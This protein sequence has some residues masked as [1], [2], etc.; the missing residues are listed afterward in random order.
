MR[1]LM[2]AGG[3]TGGHVYPLLSVLE[4]LRSLPGGA[5]TDVLFLGRAGATEEGL[6]R[7]HGVPFAPIAAG[8]VVGM[9]PWRLAR[10]LGKV[11]RGTNEALREVRR[12]D[13]DVI[14]VTGGYVS[15]PVAL[16]G[17]LAR[18]P[19]AV[20]LPDMEPGL[21]VR[22]LAYL[23]QRVTVSF[24]EVQ[25]KLPR[26]KTVVTGYPVRPHLLKGDRVAA[27]RRLGVEASEPMLLVLGGSSGARNINDAVLASLPDLLSQAR[28]F[29]LTGT[30]DFE[31]VQAAAKD[32]GT[33]VR[34]K[35]SIYSYVEEEM[36]DLLWAADLV[37]A[38][39]GAATL[40]EFPA[41]GVPSILVPGSFAGGHQSQNATYL[42]D[43][44]AA[45]VIN[46]SDLREQLL[47]AV[48]GLLQDPAQLA[49]M[50]VAAKG[51]ARPK[52]CREI[53]AELERVAGARRS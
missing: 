53:I 8:A 35:Y 6:A 45:L 32:L 19:V 30:R 34:G 39:A 50:A 37:V 25:R 42:K 40:G 22:T 9:A 23:A 20:C 2:V 52:A 7:K 15:V 44:G 14:L 10:N 4:T 29:H 41:V 38:R 33:C 17:S 48:R 5:E 49:A 31:R 27:R 51:L 12:F 43:R 11:A 16:A 47:P 24:P 28:V 18:R 46:D 21:A 1:R 3:G 13:P 36:A 26:G